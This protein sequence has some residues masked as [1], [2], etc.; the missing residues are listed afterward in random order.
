[1]S[2]PRRLAYLQTEDEWWELQCERHVFEMRQF[3]AGD[4]V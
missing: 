3:D 2:H 1:M 4:N